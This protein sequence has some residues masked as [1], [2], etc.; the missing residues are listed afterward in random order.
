MPRIKYVLAAPDVTDVECSLEA[1]D[2]GDDRNGD[3]TS[4]QPVPSST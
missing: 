1:R 4:W 3:G 2:W